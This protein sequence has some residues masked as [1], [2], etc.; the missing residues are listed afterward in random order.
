M[1]TSVA[2]VGATLLICARAATSNALEVWSLVI[3]MV[4]FLYFAAVS[5]AL[6]FI[7][8]ATHRLP[9]AI[10]MPCYPVGA[11]LLSSASLLV[12]DWQAMLTAVAGTAALFSFYFMLRYLQPT[13]MGGGDVKLAGVIGMYLGWLGWTSLAVGAFSAFLLGGAFGVV[14]LAL[15]RVKRTTPMP[16]GPWMLAGGWLGIVMGEAFETCCV[17][18]S[19]PR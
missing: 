16:F 7:D 15:G 4:A 13:G 11:V 18:L 17:G 3:T 14:L 19:L 5:I 8:V 6:T 1:L 9:N 2:F 12:G 10:V